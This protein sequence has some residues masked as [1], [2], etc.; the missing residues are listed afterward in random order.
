MSQTV[1]VSSAPEQPSNYG[2]GDIYMATE[3]LES[4]YMSCGT[5]VSQHVGHLCHLGPRYTGNQTTILHT[6]A[7]SAATIDQPIEH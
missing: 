5:L 4:N 3:T 1:K 7:V 6:V 2:A